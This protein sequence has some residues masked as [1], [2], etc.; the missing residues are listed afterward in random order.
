MPGRW[1]VQ[2][3]PARRGPYGTRGLGASCPKPSIGTPCNKSLYKLS[4]SLYSLLAIIAQTQYKRE[5]PAQKRSL[6]Q[7]YQDS[8]ELL[9][10][11]SGGL[12]CSITEERVLMKPGEVLVTV[13]LVGKEA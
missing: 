7:W 4:E 6:C 9:L 5:W 8:T 12:W 3:E 10:V 13:I 2:P 11:Q 1:W